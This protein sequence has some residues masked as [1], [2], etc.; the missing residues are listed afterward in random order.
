MWDI[1]FILFLAL[2]LGAF[3]RWAFRTLPGEGWQIIASVPRFEYAP[4]VW[5]GVNLTYYGLLIA[6]STVLAVA[7]VLVLL[8]AVGADP[9]KILALAGLIL[10]VSVPASRLV[11]RVVEKKRHTFTVAGANFVA[12]LIT[13]AIVWIVAAV[14]GPEFYSGIPLLPALA[15]MTIAYSIGEGTGRLAC[16][17]FG[18]CYGKAL[19]EIHPVLRKIIGRYSFVFRGKTKKIAYEAS[20]DEKEVVPIQAMTS[21]CYVGVGLLGML[22]YLNSWYVSAFTVTLVTTQVW[23][24][25]SEF[26]RADY[27]GNGKLS[28]YQLM[29][30]ATASFGPFIPLIAPAEQVPGP[31]LKTGLVALADPLIILVLLC[32][33]AGVF[34]YMGRSTVTASTI[35]FHV[36]KDRI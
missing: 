14:R 18:C 28:A 33:G 2:A 29:A 27:R 10:L 25:F 11:A 23:R 1:L 4:G 16:I 7:E 35:S 3:L 24:A 31:D 5:Q 36:V 20:L 13:P 15:A 19:S 17:S 34:L 8:A 30:L 9:S 21:V 32:L 22:L 12:I 26:L 6:F